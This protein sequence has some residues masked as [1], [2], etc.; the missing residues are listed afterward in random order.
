MKGSVFVTLSAD[1]KN[2]L[3]EATVAYHAQIAAAGTYLAGRGI[4]L[5]T[6]NMYLLG[7][8]AD[9]MIGHEQYAGRLAIPYLTPN[10]TVDIRFRS[11]GDD[12]GPKYLSRPGAESTLF[13]VNAFA[14]DGDVIAVCEGELDTM[15]TYGECGIPAVGVPGAKN[16]KNWWSRAF[17]DYRKVLV[18]I[19]GDAA[20]R[21]LGK[22]FAQQIDVAT[23]VSMPEG[24]DVNAVFL[25]EGADGIR[26]RVGW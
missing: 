24:M 22:K 26:K 15:I 4:S 23:V 2:L 6:A 3:D 9:P 19:D 25:Q 8:V 18:L 14:D 7:Y 11:I 5:E 20:G 21:E 17:A 13:G 12:G 16:W 10:G 1:V